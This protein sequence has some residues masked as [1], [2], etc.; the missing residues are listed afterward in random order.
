MSIGIIIKNYKEKNENESDLHISFRPAFVWGNI[1]AVTSIFINTKILTYRF[2]VILI[3]FKLL[4]II[5]GGII[6]FFIF[7]KT[8]YYYFS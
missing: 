5:F 1:L 3:L 8:R 2:K 6:C 4:S 7:V